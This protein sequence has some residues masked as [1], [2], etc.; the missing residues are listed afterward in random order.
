[1]TGLDPIEEG[2]E[3]RAALVSIRVAFVGT[4]DLG[5]QHVLRVESPVHAP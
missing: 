3:K 5:G 2:V 1:V 4:R